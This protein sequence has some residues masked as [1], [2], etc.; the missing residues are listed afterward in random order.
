MVMVIQRRMMGREER[1][2]EVSWYIGAPETWRD[3][4]RS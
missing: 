2:S 1:E 3:P 4:Y